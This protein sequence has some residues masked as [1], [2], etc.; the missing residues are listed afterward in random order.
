MEDKPVFRYFYGNEAD[1]YTFYRIPKVL[2]TCSYF[3]SLSTDAKLLYGLMLDRMSL[4]VKNQWMDSENRVFIY[5]SQEDICEMLHCGKGKATAIV[6][7][8]DAETGIGLIERRRQGQGK[9]IRIYVK[10]FSGAMEAEE[11]KEISSDSRKS[12]VLT[13]ENRD[14]RLSKIDSLDC[15]KSSP[16]D[17]E[18]I[19]NNI[20]ISHPIYP[21]REAIKSEAG[22]IDV[23]DAISVEKRR[24]WER[25]SITM[26]IKQHPLDQEMISEMAELIFEIEHSTSEK[27]YI[28]GQ[29]YPAAYVQKRF[30]MLTSD[31]LEYVLDCMKHNTT[32]IRNIRKYIL[33]ALFNAPT[34]ISSY[35]QAEANHD[36]YC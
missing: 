33:T 11:T 24:L 10:N 16:S 29:D 15:R 14:S 21:D 1:R 12:R 27:L 32:K 18:K 25:L 30:Q 3:A 23:I 13:L 17:T 22:S 20:N 31:H 2:F 28:A 34:T 26:L 35:Y 19:N 7:E 9:E 8:L 5:F 6:K 36:I 4:S